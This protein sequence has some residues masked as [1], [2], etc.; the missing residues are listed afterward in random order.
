MCAESNFRAQYTI[1]S[2]LLYYMYSHFGLHTNMYYNNALN[3]I[4]KDFQ[5]CLTWH[6]NYPVFYFQQYNAVKAISSRE[7]QY[8]ISLI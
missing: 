3:C 4:L 7:H 5:W 2:V 8:K 1:V 6:T